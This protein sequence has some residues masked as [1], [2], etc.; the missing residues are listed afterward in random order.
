[1]QDVTASGNTPIPVNGLVLSAGPGGE[2]DPVGFVTEHL[3]VGDIVTI[4]RPTTV[5]AATEADAIDPTAE[6]NPV[7][8][9][10]PGLRGPEQLIVYTPSY[11]DS[12]GTNQW[13][14]EVTV[15]G[16]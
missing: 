2:S 6:S 5:D 13:G 8:A 16:G 9:P 3:H 11:G 10:F 1:R 15:R 12:T 4:T 7:G 14:Y